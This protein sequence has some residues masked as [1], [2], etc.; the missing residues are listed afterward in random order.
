M[1]STRQ[2][3]DYVDAHERL[4]PHAERRPDYPDRKAEML[5]AL[6]FGAAGILVGFTI[7]LIFS[8]C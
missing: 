8:G 3:K 1:N 7:G 6:V 5:A 4:K 2:P